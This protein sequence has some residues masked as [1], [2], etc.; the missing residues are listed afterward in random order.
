[1]LVKQKEPRMQEDAG[2]PLDWAVGLTP[3]EGKR[4]RSKV[5]KSLNL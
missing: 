1:M 5:K 2:E 3:M 4:K